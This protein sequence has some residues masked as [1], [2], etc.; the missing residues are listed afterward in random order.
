MKLSEQPNREEGSEITVDNSDNIEQNDAS[1][2]LGSEKYPSPERSSP[3]QG[4]ET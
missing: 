1:D 3:K 4:L 2:F